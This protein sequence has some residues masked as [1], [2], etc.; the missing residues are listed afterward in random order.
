MRANYVSVHVAPVRGALSHDDLGNCLLKFFIIIIIIIN[1]T[2]ECV[3]EDLTEDV[4]LVE[5]MY[6]VFIT[7]QMELS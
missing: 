7:C 4:S 3:S 5:F 6:P 1:S 2:K